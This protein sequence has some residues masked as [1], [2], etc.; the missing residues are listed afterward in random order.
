MPAAE[1]PRTAEK[2]ARSRAFSMLTASQRLATSMK[3]DKK[4]EA[5]WS[6]YS[7]D[8][9]EKEHQHQ[10]MLLA[11]QRDVANMVEERDREFDIET[12]R[13]KL[14]NRMQIM[15]LQHQD[16]EHALLSARAE[17]TRQAAMYQ[18]HLEEVSRREQL[19][20]KK[21]AEADAKLKQQLGQLDDAAKRIALLKKD[22]AAKF[23]EA[24]ANF[25]AKREA[26][27]EKQV[28]DNKKTIT[29]IKEYAKK[30][31]AA[32]RHADEFER[33]RQSE[34]S[35]RAAHNEERR[36]A[37]REEREEALSARQN[38]LEGAWDSTMSFSERRS[39]ELWSERR[40]RAADHEAMLSSRT[41]KHLVTKT[42][43]DEA[44]LMANSQG[45]RD[46]QSRITALESAKQ[47]EERKESKAQCSEFRLKS[48][49]EALSWEMG[50]KKA[51]PPRVRQGLSAAKAPMPRAS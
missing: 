39:H 51:D 43:Q 44:K 4:W 23:A 16:E 22:Q 33:K 50:V 37:T 46:T 2:V 27:K 9:K 34:W 42:S 35:E 19:Q 24:R 15:E 28:E 30:Q 21:N 40:Q 49:I 5:G 10:M 14:E 31:A 47:A 12:E 18:S 32:E 6:R 29:A 7:G 26:I 25:A 13:A 48:D 36:Q 8:R 11:R 3:T 45:L 1:S 20:R 17:A 38:R 41:R